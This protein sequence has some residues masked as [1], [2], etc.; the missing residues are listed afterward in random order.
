MLLPTVQAPMADAFVVGM[1]LK[2]DP[3]VLK[4]RVMLEYCGHSLVDER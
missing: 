4:F 3:I 2:I 1:D